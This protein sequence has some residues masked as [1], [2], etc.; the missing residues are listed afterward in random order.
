[1]MTLEILKAKRNAIMQL[2]QQ[3][4]AYNI[5]I[6]GSV[7]RGDAGPNSDVDFL[8]TFEPNRSLFDHGGLLTDLQNLLNC[9]VD[10]MSEKGMRQRLRDH[11]FKDAVPL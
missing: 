11:V 1:M 10:V 3:W 9:K 5:R 7:A 4:G 8:V 6:F 2:A